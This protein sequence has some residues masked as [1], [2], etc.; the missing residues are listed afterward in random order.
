M[1]DTEIQYRETTAEYRNVIADGLRY[2]MAL[3]ITKYL[4][5]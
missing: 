1:N 5:T 2:I 3:G 4:M